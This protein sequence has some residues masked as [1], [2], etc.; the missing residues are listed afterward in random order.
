MRT[1]N[2]SAGYFFISMLYHN[3]ERHISRKCYLQARISYLN[4]QH[5]SIYSSVLLALFAFITR[6]SIHGHDINV[7]C[8]NIPKTSQ[9]YLATG[10]NHLLASI[11]FL[12]D[13]F[14]LEAVDIFIRLSLVCMGLTNQIKFC[15]HTIK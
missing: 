9:T 8:S 13:I 1:H 12:F 15:H 7:L 3:V 11:L 5:L 14:H 4:G 6:L 10:K 2:H